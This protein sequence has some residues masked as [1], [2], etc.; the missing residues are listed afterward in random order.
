[1]IVISHAKLLINVSMF[2][3]GWKWW[4]PPFPCCPVCRQCPWKKILIDKENRT[5]LS[6]K[7]LEEFDG[8][9]IL[10]ACRQNGSKTEKN[11]GY[12]KVNSAVLIFHFRGLL[13]IVIFRR[14]NCHEE[15]QVINCC[16]LSW[17][18]TEIQYWNLYFY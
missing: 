11:F 7:Y 2:V 10:K 17:L 6:K 18:G 1:M 15:Y 4:F 9:S 3:S 13:I 5:V 8:N 16:F 14:I 12:S